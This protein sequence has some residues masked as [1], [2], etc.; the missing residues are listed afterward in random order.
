[1]RRS[2]CPVG[3]VIVV[4]LFCAAVATPACS[5]PNQAAAP[6]ESAD[7]TSTADTNSAPDEWYEPVAPSAWSFLKEQTAS[8]DSDAPPSQSSA[9]SQPVTGLDG[10]A[11]ES[12]LSE[13]ERQK[14]D[15]ALMVEPLDL[16]VKSSSPLRLRHLVKTDSHGLNVSRTG[17]NIVV[18][19]Q[20]IVP[21]AGHW[22]A[23]VGADLGMS[24]DPAASANTD[25]PLRAQRNGRNANAAWASFGLPS[26]ATVDAR[27]NA[28]S[29]QGLVATTFKHSLPIGSALSLTLQ[30]RT[31]MTESFGPGT[32]SFDVPMMAL[33]VNDAA[34]AGATVWGQENSAKFNVASTGTSFVAGVSS[35]SADTATHNTLSA[36]QKVYGPLQVTTSITD[37]G[38]VG[39]NKSVN[40]RF[41]F[42]W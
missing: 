29:D 4:A 35:N 39:E 30:S 16:G 34:A 8:T 20:P 25:N 31:S 1:M 3:P 23:N 18:F 40:A 19:D 2:A 32:A 11:P 5:E 17:A 21:Q 9:S 22:T 28:G 12:P 36:E 42:N 7:N 26:L 13:E 15:Q 24:A 10:D 14:L 6:A 38:Q 37:V 33:P 27:V 41:K